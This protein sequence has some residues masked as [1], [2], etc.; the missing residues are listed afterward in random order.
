[1]AL[2]ILGAASHVMPLILPVPLGD[3][4]V[5]VLHFYDGRSRVFWF[6]SLEDAIRV[7]GAGPQSIIWVHSQSNEAVTLRL[8]ETGPPS[9]PS[10]SIPV[11]IGNRHQVPPIGGRWRT[12][13]ARMPRAP[14][15][16]VGPTWTV[17]STFLRLP[18]WPMVILLMIPPLRRSYVQRRA[19]RRKARNECIACG[20]NLTG[21]VTGMCPECGGNVAAQLFRDQC[22]PT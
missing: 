9:P 8:E 6:H 19:Q 16:F 12:P 2:S 3:T 13:M 10:F 18:T 17:Q 4:D 7:Q 15:Q 21:N 20:Y 22:V 5:V 14:F 11:Q 1:M